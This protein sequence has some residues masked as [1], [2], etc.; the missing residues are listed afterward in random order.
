MVFVPARNNEGFQALISRDSRLGQV[1]VFD[2]AIATPVAVSESGYL[3]IYQPGGRKQVRGGL[4]PK[5]EEIHET[6]IILHFN[7][8]TGYDLIVDNKSGLGGAIAG[9]AVGSLFGM[10]G[11]GAVVGQSISSGKAKKI[12]L[13]IKTTDFN[14]PQVIVNLY[15]ANNADPFKSMFNAVTG[16]GQQRS[17]EIQ[18]LL[19]QFDNLYNSHGASQSSNVIVQQTSDADELSKYQ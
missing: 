1:K 12:D 3:A 17:D 18:E 5:Y 16:K 9:A 6:L 19:S 15:D 4:I 8:V 7:M 13:Q 14:N 2:K 11:G 10:G